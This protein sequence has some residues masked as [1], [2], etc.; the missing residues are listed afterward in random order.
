MSRYS[1]KKEDKMEKAFLDIGFHLVEDTGRRTTGYGDKILEHNQSGLTLV[2]D[3][4]S[5]HN[6]EGI[7]IKKKQLEKIAQEAKDNGI[8]IPVI[9]FTYFNHK[10]V[11]AVFNIKQ[12]KG[13]LL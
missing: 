1:R 9:T 13:I 11:Y 12:L 2:V 4:K 8:G 7:T 6:A 10:E 3:H 5:T